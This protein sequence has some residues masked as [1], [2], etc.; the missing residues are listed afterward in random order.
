MTYVLISTRN[1]KTDRKETYMSRFFKVGVVGLLVVSALAAV[2]VGSALAQEPTPSEPLDKQFGG[3]GRDGFGR[4]G[5]DRWTMFDTTAEALGLTPEELFTELHAGKT[6]SAVAEAQGVDLQ[7]VQDAL[8][9]ARVETIQ[10]AVEDGTLTQEQADRMLN[11]LENMPT[12]EELVEAK[13]Q[14]IQQALDEGRISQEQ[15]DWLM[16]GIENGY[17]DGPGFG[18]R[19]FHK[20]GGFRGMG[21]FDGP[22]GPS[23]PGVS[24]ISL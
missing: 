11:R 2:M 5:G 4:F 18:G 21:D 10:Q 16:K 17:L 23:R 15:Y 14:A 1:T 22:R 24:G 3:W 8:K 13:K 20:F 6:L 7:A 19:G 9:A 12:Q